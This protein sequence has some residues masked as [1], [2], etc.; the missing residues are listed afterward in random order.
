VLDDQVMYDIFCPHCNKR[1]LVGTASI[2]SFHNTSEGPAAYVK[3]PQGHHLMRH[4]RSGQ[5]SAA[6]AASSN[7]SLANEAL[8]S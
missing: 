4:F 2:D 6:A 5:T 3:C 7:T 1:F 8:A